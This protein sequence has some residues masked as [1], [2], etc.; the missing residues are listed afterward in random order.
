MNNCNSLMRRCFKFQVLECQNSPIETWI[1]VAQFPICS[2][3]MDKIQTEF[4]WSVEY[5]HEV[6]CTPP[7]LCPHLSYF[8]KLRYSYTTWMSHIML[9]CGAIYNEICRKKTLRLAIFGKFVWNFIEI[10]FFF[11]FWNFA[12]ADLITEWQNVKVQFF[13]NVQSVESD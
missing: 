10:A 13:V 11:S 7:P 4:P 3:D 12:S 1:R 5:F 2:E 8:V 6:E 9:F